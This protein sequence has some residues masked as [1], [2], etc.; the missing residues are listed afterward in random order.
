MERKEA[1]QVANTIADAT[2]NITADSL[3]DTTVN[4]S[5]SANNF[6]AVTTDSESE[7][8]IPKDPDNPIVVDSEDDDH[9]LKMS[10][11]SV[12]DDAE[13]IKANDGTIVY[14]KTSNDSPV[15]LAVQPNEDGVKSLI[16]IKDSTAPKEYKFH[17]T[18][19]EGS[20]LVTA[21]DYLGDEYDTKEVFVVNSDNE[22]T[23]VFSPA[24]AKDAN[25]VDV[26][27]Y[28]KV[29]GDNL[30]Q[31]VNFTSTNAFPI[32]ADPNWSKIAK[33]SAA[34]ALFISSNL[35]AASKIIK[36]KK[37]IKALGGLGEAAKLLAGA[38]TWEEKLKIGGTAFAGLAAEITGV[39]SLSVCKPA[40]S[41]KKKK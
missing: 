13:A 26:P 30:I 40:K 12:I 33:C 7:I 3:G 5:V 41:S 4:S 21:A 16:N 34:L 14:N 10:L 22:I 19:P 15:A 37:Y 32:V 29:E 20:R 1:N 28:Y 11:P 31:V 17:I 8:K 9:S 38:T 25:G 6:N 39:A 35:F 27:T 24:W 23:S 2:S 36:I 18:L